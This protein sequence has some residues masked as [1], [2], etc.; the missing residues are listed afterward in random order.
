MVQSKAL[1]TSETHM[2]QL[3]NCYANLRNITRAIDKKKIRILERNRNTAFKHKWYLKG[4]NGM[5][6]NLLIPYSRVHDLLVI[7]GALA[8]ALLIQQLIAEKDKYIPS[9]IVTTGSW[10]V[11]KVREEITDHEGWKVLSDETAITQRLLMRNGTH[12]SISGDSPFAREPI[13]DRIGMDGNGTG[14]K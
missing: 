9:L 4:K 6:R 13:A 10:R 8:F 5:I 2:E 1:K 7:I 12:L 14:V 3:A 11:F